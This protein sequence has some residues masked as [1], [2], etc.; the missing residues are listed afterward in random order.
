[1]TDDNDASDD[2]AQPKLIVPASKPSLL[3]RLRNYFLTGIIV[4][5]PISLTVYLTW[6]FIGWV[7]DSIT[8]LLPL[9][10]HPET[11]LPF[12]VPGLGLL[13]MLVFLTFIG[14][15]T[16]NLFGRTLIR[17]GE[18]LV[19]R[20][21][22]VRTIYNALKQIMETVLRSSSQ[23]F[24]Q[25]V[26]VEYPRRGLWTLAFVTADTVGEVRRKLDDDV[27]NIY[28]PTTPNP[29]SGFLLVVPRRDVI[30]LDM[31][32][33]EAAK[34]IISTGV[35]APGEKSIPQVGEVPPELIGKL[36]IGEG[37][38]SGGRKPE[39]AEAQPDRK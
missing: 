28:V 27:I 10:Y 17:I 35:I 6:Q 7:D 20:M 30:F 19:N 15:I 8:P 4:T 24:R 5:A 36:G 29:T 37:G 31:P 3:T 25:V 18:S 13:M 11:Y 1:M 38:A 21:P 39:P 33:D 16:A 32:V 22:V 9:K 12:S 34:F 23:S 26:M 14:F 2:G